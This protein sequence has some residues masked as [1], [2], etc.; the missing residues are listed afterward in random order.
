MG[1]YGS[2][3]TGGRPTADAAYKIDLAWMLRTGRAQ[4]G[5]HIEGAL[6]WSCKGKP[7]GWVRYETIMDEP[8]QERLELTYTLSSGD[9]D[10]KVRQI[11]RLC[12]TVPHYGG[13]RWWMICPFKGIRVGKLYM[14]SRGG[15]F[16]S[17]QMW[18]LSYQV[19]KVPHRERPMERLFALQHKLGGTAGVGNMLNRPKGMWG[20]TYQRHLERS[21]ELEYQCEAQM[22][23]VMKRLGMRF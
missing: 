8:G 5:S 9:E 4:D 13:K 10:E 12:H 23:I 7:S 19:Q 14:P 15:H 20:R 17:R 18:Q 21:C 3:R 2:G 1:G 16:A 22:M 6:H 11:I